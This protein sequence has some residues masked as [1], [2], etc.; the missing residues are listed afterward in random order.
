MFV[1]QNIF[2]DVKMIRTFHIISDESFTI[3]FYL[4]FMIIK[5]MKIQIYVHSH[6]SIVTIIWASISFAHTLRRESWRSLYLLFVIVRIFPSD[7]DTTSSSE[8]SVWRCFGDYLI[9]TRLQKLKNNVSLLELVSVTFC[10][11]NRFHRLARYSL[12]FES[13]WIFSE[14]SSYNVFS[15]STFQILSYRLF[16]IFM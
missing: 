14:G 1:E 13:L 15:S 10:I 5:K 2:K 6:T 3:F 9:L 16:N 4:F 11:H 8:L 12:D 7:S